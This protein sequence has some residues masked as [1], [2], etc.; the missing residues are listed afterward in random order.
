M[1]EWLIANGASV[2]EKDDTGTTAIGYITNNSERTTREMQVAIAKGAKKA[3][4]RQEKEEKRNEALSLRMEKKRVK[5]EKKAALS[6]TSGGK[7][8][9]LTEID[10]DDDDDDV[11]P[12]AVT[13]PRRGLQVKQ[14]PSKSAPLADPSISISSATPSS[15]FSSLSSA[16]AEAKRT[17]SK[18]SLTASVVAATSSSGSKKSPIPAAPPLA[19]TSG[20]TF[21]GSKKKID[22]DDIVDWESM[23]SSKKKAT[24]TASASTAIDPITSLESKYNGGRKLDMELLDEPLTEMVPTTLSTSPYQ[25]QH[26]YSLTMLVD[27]VIKQV[28]MGF[29]RID[30]LEALLVVSK[31]ERDRSKLVKMV[32]RAIEWL[33][34]RPQQAAVEEKKKVHHLGV[35]TS[36]AH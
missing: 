3:K 19:P 14:I 9:K 31:G 18:P 28:N 1:V 36:S 11:L 16:R 20:F 8:T 29:A 34:E 15:M 33:F 30:S 25:L 13:A 10:D 5:E 17:S 27:M 12:V 32:P 4:Y 35:N 6:A 26:F 23:L 24:A 22:S 21:G 2:E 7:A